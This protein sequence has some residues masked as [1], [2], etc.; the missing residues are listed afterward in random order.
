MN[1]QS[2]VRSPEIAAEL[3]GLK[4]NRNKCVVI[5]MY[6]NPNIHFKNGEALQKVEEAL[7]LGVLITRKANTKREVKRRIQMA[8]GTLKKL[9]EF[10]HHSDCSKRLKMIV[11]VTVIRSKLLY[12]LESVQIQDHLLSQL[13]TVQLKGLRKILKW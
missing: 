9:D 10:W 1:A 8:M 11:F 12:G 3:Y 2:S 5:A 6:G 7:Y 4:F 13:N